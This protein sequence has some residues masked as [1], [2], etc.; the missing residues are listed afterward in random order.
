MS[1]MTEKNGIIRASCYDEDIHTALGTTTKYKGRI[2][3]WP[4]LTLLVLLLGIASFFIPYGAY[5]NR[6]ARLEQARRAGRFKFNRHKIRGGVGLD[7]PDLVS[8][9]GIIGNPKQYPATACQLPNYVSKNG[10]L[11]AIADNGTEVPFKIKGINWFG[12]EQ[13]NAIPFGLWQNADNGTT[14]YQIA[15][16]LSSYKFNS[17]RLPLMIQHILMNQAPNPTLINRSENRAISIRSYFSLLKSIIKA[18]QYREI[19]VVLSLHTLTVADTGGL[20]YN[21][22]ISYEDYLTAVDLLT[23]NLCSDD[24]WNVLGIDLKNEPYQATWGDKSDTD[25]VEAAEKIGNRM[26]SGCPKWLAFVEGVFESREAIIDG[27]L[28]EYN[29]WYGGGLAG[30]EEVGVHL[31]QHQKLVW[32]PHY[33]SSSV[34]PQD[35]FYSHPNRD[36]ATGLLDA[37]GELSN[38]TLRKRIEGTMESMFGFLASDHGPA[39]LMG[40]FGGLYSRDQHPKKTAQRTIDI[41]IDIISSPNWAGGFVWSLNP[42]SIFQYSRPEE[43]GDF[44]EGLLKSDWLTADENYLQALR[45]MDSMQHLRKLPCF[46]DE[47]SR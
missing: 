2:R 39:L 15:S 35:Y 10:K 25:F 3:T 16:F 9:D 40:E 18:L 31:N 33:Y 12:M 20:W 19:A 30:A 41:I 37:Y 42:E 24:Y 7:V 46:T 29:D 32:A 21:E 38:K 28:M 26:L 13:L 27:K 22:H 36:E 1:L 47:R 4:G 43:Y 5:K 44:K 6:Q 45:K 17:I 14:V 23:S 34:Y 8:D 11:Y